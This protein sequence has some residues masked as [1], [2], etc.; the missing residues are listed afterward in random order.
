MTADNAVMEPAD[1]V[2]FCFDATE[3]DA[4]Q[5]LT[6]EMDAAYGKRRWIRQHAAPRSEPNPKANGTT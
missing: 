1:P 4:I 2:H 5:R 3:E 6:D